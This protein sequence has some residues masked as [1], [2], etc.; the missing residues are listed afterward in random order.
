MHLGHTRSLSHVSLEVCWKDRGDAFF[1]A[2]VPSRAVSSARP[3]VL[4]YWS[5][6]G[7]SRRY[8]SG[9]WTTESAGSRRASRV[10]FMLDVRV[11]S[12]LSYS[13]LHGRLAMSKS[14]KLALLLIFLP[15]L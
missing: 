11:T 7:V 5:Q 2:L 8:V 9:E 4:P 15:C 3:R 12:S 6:R 10:R 1:T 13:R 14:M